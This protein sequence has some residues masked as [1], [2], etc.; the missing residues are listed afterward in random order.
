MTRS[1]RYVL[2]SEFFELLDDV[3]PRD[4][5]MARLIL[6]LAKRD[7][8]DRW[9]PEEWHALGRVHGLLGILGDTMREQD[10]RAISH[11]D[12]L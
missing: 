11:L 2:P 12:P 6:E 8:A 7:L 10:N 4:L 3:K 1:P 5:T 9:D